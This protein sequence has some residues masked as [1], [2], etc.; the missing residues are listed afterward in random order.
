MKIIQ[1]FFLFFLINYQ[2]VFAQ[3]P[4]QKEV[5]ASDYPA[6][7]DVMKKD[8]V[9]S[10]HGHTRIDPYFWMRLTDEQKAAEQ[11]DEQTQHVL[12]YL[13][14]ENAYTGKGDG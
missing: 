2:S 1:L 9:L 10:I 11:P 13:N 14:A 7:P 5:S 6:A 3:I 8:S 12:D 4:A